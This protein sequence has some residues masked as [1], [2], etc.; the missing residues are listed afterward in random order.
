MRNSARSIILTYLVSSSLLCPTCLWADGGAMRLSEQQG[1]YQIT[2]FT[3][4]TPLR[5]GLVDVS[6]FVQDAGTGEPVADVRVSVLATPR[7][8]F[9]E[10]IRQVATTEAATNKLFH[11]A[12]FDL[13]EP[14]WWELEI[15]V[16]GT[17]GP[18]QVRFPVEAA[19]PAPRW[20][21]LWP[22]FSWPAL[23]ILLFSLHQLLVRR[24]LHRP[25]SP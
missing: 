22:W 2:V 21:A 5:A 12:V 10:A 17:R 24:R 9:G 20:L 7:A 19:S 25:G 11:A 1:P 4:P 18:A 15:A 3:A 13:P 8:G 23:V 16:E 6:V 14:G